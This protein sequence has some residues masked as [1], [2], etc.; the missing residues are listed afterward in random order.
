MIETE[1]FHSEA[2]FS[3]KSETE[4]ENETERDCGIALCRLLYKRSLVYINVSPSM[5]SSLALESNI[6]VAA[7]TTRNVT[8]RDVD[9]LEMKLL[10]PTSLFSFLHNAWKVSTR[11]E[12]RR[13]GWLSRDFGS[14]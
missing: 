3:P 4:F 10:S 8:R 7:A 13:E 5:S 9:I 6:S 12:R 11:I 14:T 1:S 2:H